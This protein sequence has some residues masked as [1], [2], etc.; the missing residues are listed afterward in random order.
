MRI[1]ILA[2]LLICVISCADKTK[3]PLLS[4]ENLDSWYITVDENTDTVLRT[5]KGALLKITKGTF[6]EEVELEVKEAYTMQDML[7]G[8]LVTESDGKSLTSG[9][10]IYI[11][12]KDGSAVALL[13][14][15]GV[16]LPTDYID[17]AMQ[18]YK[19]ETDSI[20]WKPVDSLP[21]N[22]ISKNIEY[23]KKLFISN[24]ATC[25]ALDARLT[26]PALRNFR[27]RGNWK[28]TQEVYNWIRN[29]SA[30]MAKDPYTKNLHNEYG[31]VMQA[32][33]DFTPRQ[34]IAIISFLENGENDPYDDI[35]WQAGD[36]SRTIDTSSFYNIEDQQFCSDTIYYNDSR[37]T[38][39]LPEIDTAVFYNTNTFSNDTV[40][41][42]DD[43]VTLSND[44]TLAPA[45]EGLRG[46]FT[47]A[48]QSRAYV[49]EIK[50]L[51][52]YNIDAGVEGRAGT[53]LSD[54]KVKVANEI[55]QEMNVYIFFPVQKDLT[56]GVQ[57]ADQ[58]FYFEKANGK[59]PVFFGSQGVAIAFG[60]IN[61]EIYVGS[62]K[63]IAGRKQE[64]IVGLKKSSQEEFIAL[65]KNNQ[66]EGI[67]L[68][69]RKLKMSV[70]NRPCN[71]MYAT[72]TTKQ[73]FENL[74]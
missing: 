40:T 25:H 48:P 64:I 72:D 29:P 10:M 1:F 28:N 42:S 27:N 53:I 35:I 20:N 9:G 19:S 16:A 2:F 45:T 59:L 32:F 37:D 26:G 46:G 66:I 6:S 17:S 39:P 57:H 65:I 56:V 33:P 21:D 51:G 73:V 12:P 43:T 71:G 18:L 31:S 41:F 4:A 58:L 30:Y 50:T 74:K 68:N 14:P 62:K 7:L 15:I 61:D 5:P 49:F 3:R 47:D 60:S 38:L 34:I 11:N 13:K 23:G 70:V 54:T 67:D 44:A 55:L 63:F 24:C 52:W 22:K 8:A 36:S 69:I